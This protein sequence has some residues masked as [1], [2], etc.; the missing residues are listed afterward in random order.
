MYIYTTIIVKDI[1]KRKNISD[2]SQLE[3]IIKFMFENIGNICTGTKVAN[4]MTSKGRKISVPTV[5]S[6]L[7]ALE[8][9][10]ILYKVGRYD[11]KGK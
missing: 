9:A 7:G 5:E 11:I 2:I 6:Y 3:N 1:A 8:D 4:T 10:F